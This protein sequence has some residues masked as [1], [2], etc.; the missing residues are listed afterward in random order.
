MSRDVK[1]KIEPDLHRETVSLIRSVHVG[2]K[3]VP[4]HTNS[5]VE[6]F[7]RSES[8]PFPAVETVEVPI[9]P[10]SSWPGFTDGSSTSSTKIPQSMSDLHCLAPIVEIE[11]EDLSM[12]HMKVVDGWS[13]YKYYRLLSRLTHWCVSGLPPGFIPVANS[14]LRVGRYVEPGGRIVPSI[15]SCGA[16]GWR[17]Y[18]GTRVVE[19]G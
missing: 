16:R 18:F 15:S 11:E 2:I 9:F 13:T 12:E 4:D 8:P 3:S 10:R 1:Y 7:L 6:A 14:L 19:N 5:S 17:V